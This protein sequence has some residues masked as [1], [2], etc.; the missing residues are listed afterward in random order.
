MSDISAR[1]A[2][3]YATGD[4]MLKLY[5]VLVVGWMLTFLGESVARSAANS[6][7]TV[8]A[9]IGALVGIVA[10]LS[11]IVAIAYKVL[12]DGRTA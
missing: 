3:R 7:V 11:G 12:A 5:G 1:E 6:G 9:L 2:L 10:V 4:D 8:L